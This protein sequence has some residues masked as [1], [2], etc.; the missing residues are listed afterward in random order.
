MY[1]TDERSPGDRLGHDDGEVRAAVRF[2]LAATVAGIGFLI[3]ALLWVSTCPGTTVDTVACGAPE[4]TLLAAGGPAILLL[5]GLWAFL[6][7]YRVRDAG[8]VWWGWYGAGWLLLTLMA[9]TLV[10]GV[11][12]IAGPVVAP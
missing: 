2:A 10:A 3:L 12:P 6:R 7:S 9:L 1:R 8:R 4:R 11:P 5:A